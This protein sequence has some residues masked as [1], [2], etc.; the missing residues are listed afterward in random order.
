MMNTALFFCT[1]HCYE[2]VTFPQVQL[3]STAEKVMNLNQKNPIYDSILIQGG[4]LRTWSYRSPA[5]EQVQV[6]LSSEG[7]PLDA[8]V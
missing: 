2:S 3:R 1:L 8:V 6:I 5:V 4:S 7:R